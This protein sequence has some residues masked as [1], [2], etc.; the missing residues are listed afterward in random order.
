MN[1]F[2]IAIHENMYTYINFSYETGL[3]V[4]KG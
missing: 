2:Y 4:V 1:T 3:A